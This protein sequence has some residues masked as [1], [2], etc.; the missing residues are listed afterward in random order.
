VVVSRESARAEAAHLIEVLADELFP[1]PQWGLLREL[2]N[3]VGMVEEC[4]YADGIAFELSEL[5]GYRLVG[6][7]AKRTK[8]DWQRELRRPEKSRRFRRFCAEWYV[9]VKAPR[10]RI[11]EVSELPDGVGLIEVDGPRALRLVHAVEQKAEPP[12]PGLLKAIVRNALARQ[13]ED[14]G[15]PLKTVVDIEGKFA[16]LS[17]GDR[18]VRPLS[19]EPRLRCWLCAERRVAPVAGGAAGA[20][21]AAAPPLAAARPRRARARKAA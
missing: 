4:G 15:A 13:R 3:T 7:E 11:L 16:V 14:A 18:I 10:K 5:G 8:R 6:F 12:T 19:Y 2:R 21:S 1:W 20:A 9:V 17:C